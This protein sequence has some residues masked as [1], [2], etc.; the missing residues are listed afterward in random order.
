VQRY[1]G[2]IDVP[3]S[4]NTLINS[5][6]NYDCSLVNDTA[7]TPNAGLSKFQFTSGKAH[8]LRL[9]NG[10]AEGLQKFSIDNHTMTVIA[11]DFTPIIP[12]NTDV[13]TLGVGQRADV[14]VEA[15]GQPGD[16]VWMRTDISTLCSHPNQPHALAA[17]Y[18][19]SANTST[20]PEST[21]T[22]Y[23][24]TVNCTQISINVTEP[25]FPQAL[26]ESPAITQN[27]DILFG[28]NATGAQVW[29]VNNIS[30]R[31]NYE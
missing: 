18:Y 15:L 25:Y 7:C 21:A 14:L 27:I 1:T 9:I 28:P 10:G 20:T 12:Y 13:I 3:Y 4:N 31:A 5:K 16:A 19:E 30:F 11:N 8:R 17:I 2:S 26:P 24:A 23:N 22:L 6:M 29:F